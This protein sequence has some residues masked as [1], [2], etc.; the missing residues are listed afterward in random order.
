M[1]LRRAVE[2][3]CDRAGVRRVTV[4][5]LRHSFASLSA[6][7]RIPAEISME[8]GGWSNDKIMKEIYTHIARSDIERYKN[9]MWIFYN[10][11]SANQP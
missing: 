7:L 5:Q 8:I 3:T 1:T 10:T 6:H 4:H 9:E 11:R 2:R